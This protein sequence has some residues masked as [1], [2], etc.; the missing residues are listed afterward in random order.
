MNWLNFIP[1]HIYL[2]S[3]IYHFSN[4]FGTKI[5]CRIRHAPLNGSHSRNLAFGRQIVHR[6]VELDELLRESFVGPNGSPRARNDISRLWVCLMSFLACP[7]HRQR[8][9]APNCPIAWPPSAAKGWI[10]L[11][12]FLAPLGSLEESSCNLGLLCSFHTEWPKWYRHTFWWPSQWVNPTRRQSYFFQHL[13]DYILS[14][15]WRS[16]DGQDL[17]RQRSLLEPSL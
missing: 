10:L 13:G 6:V 12:G 9:T 2:L 3:N 1:F 16:P 5:Y 17:L 15:N 7:K 11:I 8:V 14:N 4:K